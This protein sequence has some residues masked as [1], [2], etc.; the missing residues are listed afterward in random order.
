MRALAATLSVVVL[1]GCSS[2]APE[3]HTCMLTVSGNVAETSN[4]GD[5]CAT[6]EQSTGSGYKLHVEGSTAELQSFRLD[7]NLGAAPAAGAYSSATVSDWGASALRTGDETCILSAGSNSVPPGYFALDVDSV[8]A[9]TG[10]VAHGSLDLVMNVRAPPG[11]DCG[12]GDTEHV[13]LR[14]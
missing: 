6:L 5:D 3:D 1:A 4:L 7:F 2:P 9:K 8:E 11:V 10:G 13:V 14:F 12:A